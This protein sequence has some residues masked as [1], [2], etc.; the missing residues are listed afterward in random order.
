MTHSAT[1]QNSLPDEAMLVWMHDF[2]PYGVL[3]TDR[4][5]RIQSWNHW[6][7][8]QTGKKSEEVVGRYLFEVFPDLK[9]R[10]LQGRF[11]RALDGESSL[12][13]TALHK[14]LLRMETR[15]KNSIFHEMQQTARIAP[16]VMNQRVVGTIVVV[17]DVTQRELQGELLRQQHERDRILSWALAHLIESENPKRRVREL[18]LKIAEHLDWEAYLLYLVSADGGT[19]KLEAVGGVTPE[20]EAEISVLSSADSLGRALIEAGRA[21][22]E[23]GTA[24]AALSS[25]ILA[26]L[27]FT[28]SAVLPLFSAERQIGLLC[29][30]ARSRASVR[31]DE[32]E[33]LST[34]GKYLSAALHK[35]ATHTELK[36]A[37]EKLNKYTENLERDVAKR[38]TE[39]SEAN[40]KLRAEIN[41]RRAIEESRAALLRQLV[42]AEEN[43]RSRIARELHDEMGQY[44][45]ALSLGLK[46][47]SNA[48]PESKKVAEMTKGLERV[49]NQIGHQVHRLAVELRPTALDDLGLIRMLE[50]YIKAWGKRFKIATDFQGV[51]YPERGVVPEMETTLYRTVQEALN[52]VAKHAGAKRVS[53]VLE[54]TRSQVQVIIE[55]D[56]QGFDPE[57]I[58]SSKTFNTRLG[59]RG[60][61]E[62]LTLL[63]GSLAI[64]SSKKSGTTIFARI[65]LDAKE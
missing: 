16:L 38:T 35:E 46:R 52:N 30:G 41:E 26:E 64:E 6:I 24:S 58:L 59:L 20:K 45:T 65:P 42:H 17:E 31:P 8:Y 50:N 40:A 63:G 9:E 21:G 49:T 11:E 14:Y 48:V 28:V 53:I 7:A 27:G 12:L 5:L 4:D 3:T 32:L 54:R 43:E 22:A 39:L 36:R 1:L 47:L 62:R 2:A 10:G 13:S 60:M 18:F 51:N 55:D 33:L 61:R 37:Q 19:L 15:L 29:F 44:V 23:A 34:I 57:S 25:E 56:G